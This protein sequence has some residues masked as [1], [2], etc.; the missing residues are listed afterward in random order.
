MT[1]AFAH[2]F[3]FTDAI[4]AFQITRAGKDEDGKGVIKAVISGPDVSTK[5]L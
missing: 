4:R 1:T 5:D 3:A 2:S